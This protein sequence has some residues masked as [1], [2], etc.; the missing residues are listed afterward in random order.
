MHLSLQKRYE[1]PR[2]EVIEI[3]SQGVLCASDG[4]ATMGGGSTTS[5]TVSGG[6]GW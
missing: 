3:E 4:A 2:V 5:M 6:Y 1:A